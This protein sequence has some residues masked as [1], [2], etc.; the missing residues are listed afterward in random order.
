MAVQPLQLVMAVMALRNSCSTMLRDVTIV[1]G[2]TD[3]LFC[4]SKSLRF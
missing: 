3:A 1:Y 4:N 2:I